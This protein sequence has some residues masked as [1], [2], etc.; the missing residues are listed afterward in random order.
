MIVRSLTKQQVAAEPFSVWN[1]FVDL[2]A[3]EGYQRLSPEQRPAHLVFFYDSEV[4]NGGHL[5]FFHNRGT[6][7]LEETIE[8]LGLLGAALHQQI[9]RE[10]DKLWLNRSRPGIQ[11]LQEFSETA[12]EGEFDALDSRFY[13][14]V[15]T[16][17]EQLEAYLA[18]H[19]ELFV[20]VT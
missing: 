12:M 16:L 4:Q 6:E 3:R 1:A 18:S 10:A 17:T 11:T 20:R 7:Y 19:Q 8:A 2:L 9:L 14:S 15:P 5:Q 13:K